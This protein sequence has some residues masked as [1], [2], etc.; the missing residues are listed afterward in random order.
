MPIPKLKPKPPPPPASATK[1]IFIG[2][3]VKT[4]RSGSWANQIRE[5]KSSDVN[6]VDDDDVTTPIAL[7]SP[8]LFN[9]RRGSDIVGV[10]VKPEVTSSSCGSLLHFEVVP[11]TPKL[12][13]DEATSS[14]FSFDTSA[15]L[16]PN[17]PTSTSTDAYVGGPLNLSSDAD[18]DAADEYDEMEDELKTPKVFFSGPMFLMPNVRDPE[19]SSRTVRDRVEQ[20][21]AADQP[22]MSGSTYLQVPMNVPRRRHS[23]I[24]G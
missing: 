8:T 19:L 20:A 16:L 21:M 2:H 6:D 15:G 7:S 22:G 4:K 24:C 5:R 3:A 10:G 14:F 18:A 17:C 13:D 11:P 12:A 9:D 23:W 1:P